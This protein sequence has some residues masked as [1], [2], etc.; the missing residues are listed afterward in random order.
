MAL[1]Q[2][3][4]NLFLFLTD[5]RD[6]P[7]SKKKTTTIDQ[8]LYSHRTHLTVFCHI[9]FYCRK[10]FGSKRNS[11]KIRLLFLLFSI[12]VSLFSDFGHDWFS[13][14]RNFRDGH[15]RLNFCVVFL[16]PRSILFSFISFSSL[17]CLLFNFRMVLFNFPFLFEIH[18]VSFF[19]W[20]M[21]FGHWQLVQNAYCILLNSLQRIIAIFY[22]FYVAILPIFFFI[23]TTI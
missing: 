7:K 4:Q 14:H 11:S 23:Y 16:S 3:D 19:V 18:C 5:R 22:S 12:I 10:V 1:N 6:R 8:Y 13:I 15:E 9:S 2:I 20:R 17:N 21:V